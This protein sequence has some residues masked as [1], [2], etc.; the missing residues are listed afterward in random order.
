[1]QR[2]E[3]IRKLKV[4]TGPEGVIAAPEQLLTPQQFAKTYQVSVSWLAKRRKKGGDG[5]PFVR[6]GKAVRYFPVQ[7]PK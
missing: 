2:S 6:F 3:L 1:M 7:K 4:I 5:P